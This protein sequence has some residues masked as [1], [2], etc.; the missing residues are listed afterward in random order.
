MYALVATGRAEI[1][2]DS[3]MKVWD[4]AALLPVVTEAGGRFTDWSGRPTHTA[5]EA[6]ATNGQ[7]HAEVLAALA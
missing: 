7:L 6:L 2:L 3:I 5:P 4:N 1:A